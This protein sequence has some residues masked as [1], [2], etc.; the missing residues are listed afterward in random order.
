[1]KRTFI[2]LITI[3]TLVLVISLCFVLS[4]CDDKGE[5]EYFD[6]EVT[7]KFATGKAV[8]M[9]IDGY[10]DEENT[11]ATFNPDGSMVIRL[12][13]KATI[14]TAANIYLRMNHDDIAGISL[15]DMERYT[16]EVLPGESFYNLMSALVRLG[17]SMG[18]KIHGI[19]YD[20]PKVQA[21]FS[22]F[23]ETRVIPAS[24]SLPD[25]LYITIE[26]NYSLCKVPS[27]FREEP[28]DA[29]Y[30]GDYKSVNEDPF[31]ILTRYKTEDNKEALFI[32]N[33]M[34]SLKIDFVVA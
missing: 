22:E 29:I 27:D 23:E 32:Y 4:A 28:F 9:T 11:Y 5:R 20:D 34:T 2:K 24:F 33:E 10:I 6:S 8:D 31:I 7:Y 25:G 16:N 18:V 26:A 13:P 15:S 21:V 3:F 14:I 17:D 12:T 19:D 30:L 1:M